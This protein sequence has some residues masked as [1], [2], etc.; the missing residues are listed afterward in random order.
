MEWG[1]RFGG[2]VSKGTSGKPES[3]QDIKEVVAP[4]VELKKKQDKKRCHLA[5]FFNLPNPLVQ[6]LLPLI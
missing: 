4:F 6:V 3:F 5:S 1:E 2:V